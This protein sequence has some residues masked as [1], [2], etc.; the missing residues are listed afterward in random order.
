MSPSTFLN[1]AMGQIEGGGAPGN[2]RR[3][4]TGAMR[5]RTTDP[6]I[7]SQTEHSRDLNPRQQALLHQP[8]NIVN[9]FIGQYLNTVF[10]EQ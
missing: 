4:A 1:A 8:F 6:L 9:Q 10:L 5:T 3:A 2:L 7:K